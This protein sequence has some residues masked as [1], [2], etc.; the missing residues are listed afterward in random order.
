[1]VK[2]ECGTI[3]YKQYAELG[4]CKRCT[5]GRSKACAC[6]TRLVPP[7]TEFCRQCSIKKERIDNPKPIG[8]PRK[9]TPESLQ[10]AI[11]E[12]SRSYYQKHKEEIKAKRIAK[13]MSVASLN[14]AV[15][16]ST[17]SSIVAT[18]SGTESE[19]ESDES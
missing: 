15:S 11:L 3:L 9:H 13:R 17:Q 18:E 19:T 2:C 14:R 7:Y 1:M 4:T 6:G 8:R 5:A 16:K 10:V 12:N